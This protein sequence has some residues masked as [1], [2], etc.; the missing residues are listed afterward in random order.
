M[1]FIPPL[2]FSETPEVEKWRPKAVESLRMD[3]FAAGGPENLRRF[4]VFLGE[5][6]LDGHPA[7]GF[8]H[9]L[10]SPRKLGK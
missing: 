5:L 9:F 6:F 3:D 7:G 1:T 2:V 10:F 4:P 8:K